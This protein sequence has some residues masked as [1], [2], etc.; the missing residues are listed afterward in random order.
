MLAGSIANNKLANSTISGVSLG[1]NLL[2]LTAGYGLSFS[3][4]TTYNGSTA[5]TLNRYE[6]VATP[7]ATGSGSN[8]WT[9][10]LDLGTS[11]GLT[12]LNVGGNFSGTVTL[13]GTPVVGRITRLVIVGGIKGP[14]A[15]TVS[16]LT[17]ANSSNGTNTFAATSGTASSVIVEFY[18]STTALSGVYM[19]CSGAK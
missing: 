8:G 9:Y 12:F 16:G 14:T 6:G 1:G 4:G 11:T 13:T 2:S 19:N 3:A 5:L 17:A 18:S 15:V 10:S 7:T